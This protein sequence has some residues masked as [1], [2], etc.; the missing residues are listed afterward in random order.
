MRLNQKIGIVIV[1]VAFIIPSCSESPPQT[2]NGLRP[3]SELTLFMRQ[4][5]AECM[6]EKEKVLKGEKAIFTAHGAIA[7]AQSTEP[8][9]AEGEDYQEFAAEYLDLLKTIKESNSKDNKMLYQTLVD[10]C[11]GCHEA[12]CPGPLRRIKNLDI[13][14]K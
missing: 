13:S 10:G 12:L 6:I 3:P 2:N 4:L 11:K 1:A 7:T 9:K 5:Y 14:L 8:E